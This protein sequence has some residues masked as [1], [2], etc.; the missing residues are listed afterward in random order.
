M[1]M[2]SDVFHG[3]RSGRTNEAAIRSQEEGT[4]RDRHGLEETSR[5]IY[6]AR[7]LHWL[8]YPWASRSMSLTLSADLACCTSSRR[9][10][11]AD[12]SRSESST[13]ESD[14]LRHA[15]THPESVED[16]G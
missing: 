1:H 9:I 3:A 15:R 7:G 14:R 16:R 5:Y 11:P 12:S 8:L 13:V 10:R 2:I 4:E 6:R